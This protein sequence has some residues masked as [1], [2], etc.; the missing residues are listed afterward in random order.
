MSHSCQES[1]H[2]LGRK[3]A[4]FV[5]HFRINDAVKLI[6]NEQDGNSQVDSTLEA[7][8]AQSFKNMLRTIVEI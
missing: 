1:F 8:K 4:K 3:N 2:I 6:Q 7:Q 5:I